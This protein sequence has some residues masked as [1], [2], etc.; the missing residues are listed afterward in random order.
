MIKKTRGQNIFWEASLNFLKMESRPQN[1]NLKFS[2]LLMLFYFN[3]DDI[4]RREIFDSHFEVDPPFSKN[5]K[6]LENI[7][8]SSCFYHQSLYLYFLQKL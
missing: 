2:L 1:V 5:S 8:T 4:N 7:L 3:L 6:S